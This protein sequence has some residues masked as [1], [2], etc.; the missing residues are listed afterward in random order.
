MSLLALR[1]VYVDLIPGKGLKPLVSLG[2]TASISGPPGK[3]LKPLV[4]RFQATCLIIDD[5]GQ[6]IGSVEDGFIFTRYGHCLYQCFCFRRFLG[7]YGNFRR[8]VHRCGRGGFGNRAVGR[9]N[10]LADR[11]RRHRRA[12][13]ADLPLFDTPG[14]RDH[15]PA[16]RSREGPQRR[17]GVRARGFRRKQLQQLEQQILPGQQRSIIPNILI[18]LP[19]IFGR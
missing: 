1:Q 17:G 10:R 16:V 8:P 12:A 3:G 15:R 9:R 19:N 6:I 13:G 7:G 2:I 14:R 4:R 18:P 5:R 11:G